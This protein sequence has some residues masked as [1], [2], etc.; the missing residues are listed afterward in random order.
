MLIPNHPADERL[1][2]FAD[3][4]P[5][6]TEPAIAEHVASCARCTGTVDEL[7]G[8]QTALAAMPDIAPSRPLQL[9]PPVEDLSP[10]ADRAGSWVRRLFGPIL[11]T[12]AA[13]A[14]VGAVGTTAPILDDMAS[15]AGSGQGDSAWL[16]STA[17]GAPADGGGAELVEPAAS[18]ARDSAASAEADPL[19]AGEDGGTDFQES[20]SD[21][22]TIASRLATERSPWPMVLFAGIALIIGALL[23]RWVLVPRAG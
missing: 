2:A 18:A 7:M 17:A 6:A 23:L 15:G 22:G 12:G 1:A 13:V 4:D 16:E 8:L 5:E 20:G 10:A 9:V 21:E 3:R 14:L 19:V 11:V